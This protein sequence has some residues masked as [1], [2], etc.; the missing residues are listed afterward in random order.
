[1]AGF[2]V[3]ES[4]TSKHAAMRSIPASGPLTGAYFDVQGDPQPS[5]FSRHTRQS[6]PLLSGT[7]GTF[8]ALQLMAACV[9]GE[10]PPDFSGYADP[11]IA[12]AAARIINNAGKGSSADAVIVALFEYCRDAIRYLD[13]PWNEQRVQDARRTLELGTG[14]CVS[15]SVCLSTLLASQGIPSRF[16]AQA[17]IN[18]EFNHVYVEVPTV[19]GY[20]GLDPVASGTEGKPFGAVGWRQELPDY[21]FESTSEIFH[22]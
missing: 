3:H 21:G 18:N 7:A 16:V 9:R 4:S 8:Q 10:C 19:R 5:F 12:T 22:A 1:M 6:W 13:H 17:P 14:D 2:P 20:V 15:K 11:I